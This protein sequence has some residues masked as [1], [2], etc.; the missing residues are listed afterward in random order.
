M[1]K[2]IKYESSPP[3]LPIETDLTVLVNKMHQQLVYLEKKIDALI[4]Q[5]SGRSSEPRQFSKPS[6]QRPDHERSLHKAICADCGNECE[7]PFR[8][9]GE[10]PVYCRE[11]FSD[12]KDD[13]SSFRDR[14]NKSGERDFAQERHF[15]KHRGGEGRRFGGKTKP[16][17][18]RRK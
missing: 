4:S 17:F 10:R 11:C 7:V 18:R 13:S 16:G 2:R 14:H 3:P 15:G 12:H 5:S 6:F 8:P 9:T 1:K